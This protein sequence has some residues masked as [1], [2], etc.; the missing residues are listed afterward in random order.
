MRVIVDWCDPTCKTKW[1]EIDLSYTDTPLQSLLG[2]RYLIKKQ[3]DSD[4]IPVWIKVPLDISHNISKQVKIERNARIL[5]WPAYDRD[6]PLQEW[7]ED[8]CSGHKRA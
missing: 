4:L 3:L 2:D 8:L 1:K 7:I 6:F 5:R